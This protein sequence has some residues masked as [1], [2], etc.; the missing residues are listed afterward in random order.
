MVGTGWQGH[1]M[2]GMDIMSYLPQGTKACINRNCFKAPSIFLFPPI[3]P[4][5]SFQDNQINATVM[6][7]ETFAK[8][9]KPFHDYS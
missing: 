7:L 6:C 3:I 9:K 4:A 2:Q 1:G 5:G 8:L